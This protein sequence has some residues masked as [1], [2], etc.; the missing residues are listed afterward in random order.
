MTEVSKRKY[1]AY[2]KLYAQKHE[3]S[4]EEAKETRMVELVREYYEKEDEKDAE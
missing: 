4:I 2:A 3:I 1:E